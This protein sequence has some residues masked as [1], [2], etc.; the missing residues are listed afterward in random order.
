MSILD[1]LN[2][3]NWR[4]DKEADKDTPCLGIAMNEAGL[5][6]NHAHNAVATIIKEQYPDR[7]NSTG[8][9]TIVHFNDH[10]D[11]TWEDIER[12]VQ[13]FEAKSWW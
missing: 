13:K 12:V 7:A 1:I 10:P 5:A 6:S 9:G 3:D 4:K 8:M 11:T 2:S